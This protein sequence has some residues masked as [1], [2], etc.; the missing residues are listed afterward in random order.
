MKWRWQLGTVKGIGIYIHATVLLLLGWF[1]ISDISRGYG[2]EQALGEIVF[3]G[4]ILA[5]V[6]LHELGHALTAQKFGIGTRDITLWPIGGIARLE[7][8]PSHPFQELLISIAG[9]AVNIV[10]AIVLGLFIGLG[11]IVSSLSG[12]MAMGSTIISRLMIANIVLAVFNLLPAFPMDGGRVLRSFLAM[13]ID[14][15]KATSIAATLGKGMA[16]LFGLAGL[17]GNPF[18]ILIAFFVWNAANSELIQSHFHENGSY[19]YPRNAS[20]FG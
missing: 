10:I 14:Y 15:V 2:V 12:E 17:F 18:L 11:N 4:A 20:V 9:P 16:V 3:I 8:M 19:F 1:F 7:R 6:I 13:R 5:T